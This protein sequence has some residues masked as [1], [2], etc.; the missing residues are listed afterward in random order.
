MRAATLMRT[1]QEQLLASS[2][3]SQEETWVLVLPPW[4]HLYHWKSKARIPFHP[5]SSFFDVPSL[6]RFVPT[7]EFDEYLERNGHKI[8]EVGGQAQG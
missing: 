3:T 8:D 5:W 7:I 1:L 6:N 2:G 4:P